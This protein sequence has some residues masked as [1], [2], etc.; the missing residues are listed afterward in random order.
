MKIRYNSLSEANNKLQ[1]KLHME[2]KKSEQAEI[3][4]KKVFKK[5]WQLNDMVC[6]LFSS[7]EC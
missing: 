1:S 4:N 7:E 3:D 5:Y 2:Q 6:K